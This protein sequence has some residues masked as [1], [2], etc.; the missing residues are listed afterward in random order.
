MGDFFHLYDK[1]KFKKLNF[2][3][4]N[5]HNQKQIKICNCKYIKLS[6]SIP[7]ICGQLVY[8]LKA[9]HVLNLYSIHIESGLETPG[10]HVRVSGARL[11]WHAV[12]PTA[13]LLLGCITNLLADSSCSRHLA[14]LCHLPCVDL[15]I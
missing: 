14:E 3:E 4:S 2:R 12:R 7:Y 11:P 10:T 1:N 6:E 13:G 8:L 15:D 5:S 9:I